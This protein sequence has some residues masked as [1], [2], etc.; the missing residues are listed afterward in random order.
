[1]RQVSFRTTRLIRSTSLCD[2]ALRWFTITLDD[3]VGGLW[4][5]ALSSSTGLIEP[6]SDLPFFS[7]KNQS[8]WY[9]DGKQKI[10]CTDLHVTEQTHTLLSLI[11]QSFCLRV[12]YLRWGCLTAMKHF[13]SL[14]FW[15]SAGVFSLSFSLLK[16]V[17]SIISCALNCLHCILW[18]S[19]FWDCFDDNLCSR[20][21]TKIIPMIWVFGVELI[22]S[23][24]LAVSST[25][26]FWA[27]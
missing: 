10:V 18:C 15:W 27:C 12:P 7:T 8:F 23:T 4:H 22:W 24:S 1:M 14:H 13:T 11:I 6:D 2:I 21:S 3:S 16:K 20:S 9:C 19:P 17:T 5:K 25:W 26:I